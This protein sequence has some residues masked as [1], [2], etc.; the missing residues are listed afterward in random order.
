VA[1]LNRCE[2]KS[3]KSGGCSQWKQR[4]DVCPPSQKKQPLE[5]SAA[6]EQT[7]RERKPAAK[8]VVSWKKKKKG[9]SPGRAREKMRNSRP[10]E[11]KLLNFRQIMR[12]KKRRGNSCGDGGKGS[13]SRSRRRKKVVKAS[14]H[15]PRGEGKM[16]KKKVE[17]KESE[18]GILP[19]RKKRNWQ[20]AVSKRR[21]RLEKARP[22]I[23]NKSSQKGKRAPLKRNGEH[24]PEREKGGPAPFLPRKN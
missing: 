3:P 10:F 13:A 21:G 7:K 8:G 1:P 24:A 20:A 16:K 2:R 4:V 17:T 14:K 5:P 18:A 15:T 22:D 11:K 6:R 19:G 9:Q 23:R 12:D